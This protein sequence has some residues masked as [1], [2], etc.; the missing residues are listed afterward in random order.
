MTLGNKNILMLQSCQF[1]DDFLIIS[2]A[3]MKVMNLKR[4][5]TLLFG[6]SKTE[7]KLFRE[8]TTHFPDLSFTSLTAF[9]HIS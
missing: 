8:R 1:F 7:V 5:T 6:D 2:D 9:E 4:G 3:Q